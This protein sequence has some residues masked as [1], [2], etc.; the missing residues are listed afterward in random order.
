MCEERFSCTYNL[1]EENTQNAPR[2][3]SL[4]LIPYRV[5]FIVSVKLVLSGHSKQKTKFGFHYRLS[6]NAGQ[7]YCR[8][9]Q[10]EHSAILMT[11]IKLTFSKKTF[12][13]SILSGL[14]KTGFN[15]L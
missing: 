14:F 7:N 11:I 12:L 3:L 4:S 8:T 6:L 10:G 1:Q 5:G 2:K 13:M 15:A 9:L